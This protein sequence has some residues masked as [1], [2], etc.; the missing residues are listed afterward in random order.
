MSL[1]LVEIMVVAALLLGMGMDVVF[2]YVA[3]TRPES[4]GN[5]VSD[6]SRAVVPG[7]RGP[8]LNEKCHHANLRL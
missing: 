7:G 2:E 6:C 3:A 4:P 1:A 8:G 5:G